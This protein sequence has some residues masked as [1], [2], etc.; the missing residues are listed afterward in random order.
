MWE[1]ILR[2]AALSIGVTACRLAYVLGR[3]NRKKRQTK[4]YAK[5]S[6]KRAA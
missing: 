5:K 2:W 3:S 1:D 4:Q 6:N